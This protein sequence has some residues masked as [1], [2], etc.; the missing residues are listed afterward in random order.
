MNIFKKRKQ[1]INKPNAINIV[2]ISQQ[3]LFGPHWER[4]IIRGWFWMNTCSEQPLPHPGTRGWRVFTALQWFG[5][6]TCFYLFV[7]LRFSLRCSLPPYFGVAMTAVEHGIPLISCPYIWQ[8]IGSD[9]LPHPGQPG[10]TEILLVHRTPKPW[11]R[12]GF[13]TLF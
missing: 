7:W 10:I 3:A 11:E 4:N 1:C 2:R 6:K 13:E 9:C 8:T 12:A 5:L